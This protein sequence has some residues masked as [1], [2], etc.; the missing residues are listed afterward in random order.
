MTFP[1]VPSWFLFRCSTSYDTSYTESCTT[2]TAVHSCMPNVL[3][4]RCSTPSAICCM[5]YGMISKVLYNTVEH[6]HDYLWSMAC[7][8]WY[9]MAC[10]LRH[11]GMPQ[12]L[13]LC[14]IMPRH[15]TIQA[16]LC[17]CISCKYLHLRTYVRTCIVLACVC[18]PSVLC[19]CC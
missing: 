19:M 12:Q 4:A 3:C 15:R 9:K 11:L 2:H 10:Y 16:R 8:V 13:V 14:N 7:D 18:V 5:P 17:T 1:S 6:A